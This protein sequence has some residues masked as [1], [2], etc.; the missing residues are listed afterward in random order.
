MS[1]AAAG[2]APAA[3]PVHAGA[4]APEQRRRGRAIDQ[5]LHEPGQP[6]DVPCHPRAIR[7]RELRQRRARAARGRSSAGQ[8]PRWRGP[9]ASCQQLWSCGGLRR[10]DPK[11]HALAAGCRRLAWRAVRSRGG[12]VSRGRVLV[13]LRPHRI[14][15]G[16]CRF[17]SCGCCAFLA[18]I[19]GSRAL[20]AG[21]TAAAV[22]AAGCRIALACRR[23]AG[24]GQGRLHESFQCQ[25]P[26]MFH[27]LQA[28]L[29]GVR[30]REARI[31]ALA[32]LAGRNKM[33]GGAWIAVWL[34]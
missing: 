10:R 16:S 1:A 8:T 21:A 29:A 7:R 15:G 22:A 11:A 30:R 27:Q 18:T 13:V 31:R 17:P 28:C 12:P 32:A 4:H 3:G 5:A 23:W 24:A 20:F 34:C 9:A 6:P 25:Q 14:E 19:A 33:N 2:G 26:T